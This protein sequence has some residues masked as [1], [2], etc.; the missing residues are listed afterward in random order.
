MCDEE[1]KEFLVPNRAIV[2]GWE[3]QAL[4]GRAAR[5]LARKTGASGGHSASIPQYAAPYVMQVVSGGGWDGTNREHNANSP[6]I[7]LTALRRGENTELSVYLA[8]LTYNLERRLSYSLGF[9]GFQAFRVLLA[10]E[11]I[12]VRNQRFIG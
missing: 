3:R 9:I 4:I 10:W 5:P 7:A 6:A 12:R 8:N 11:L 1:G 2:L